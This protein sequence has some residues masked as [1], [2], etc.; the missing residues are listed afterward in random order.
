MLRSL[1]SILAVNE[2]GA[3]GAGNTLPW[4]VRTDLR[5][6]REHTLRNVVIM[7]RKTYD[8][9]GGGLPDRSNIVVTHG[10]G[11]F[12]TTPSCRAAGSIVEALLM[13]DDIK[14]KKQEVLIVGGASMYEQFAPYV[15]R[16]LIT[17]IQK[18]VPNADTFFDR[19]IIGNT[20]DWDIAV[21]AQGR[22]DGL[23]DECDFTIYEFKV[24]DADRPMRRREGVL[25][26]LK[27]R[28]R[29]QTLHDEFPRMRAA[30]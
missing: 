14:T 22:A 21:V 28:R 2:D 4:R 13:A 18:P 25:E 11:M 20:R 23:H 29:G 15:D 5:F 17:E 8:S 12:P 19:A 6:F 7:G 3:I 26:D 24:K 9:L 30:G 10:F 1:T 27:R 16:Y